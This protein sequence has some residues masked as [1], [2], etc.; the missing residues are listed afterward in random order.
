[1]RRHSSADGHRRGAALAAAAAA[2]AL[3]VLTPSAPARAD[4]PWCALGYAIPFGDVICNTAVSGAKA[5]AKV[6]SFAEDPL[7]YLQ[8][9]L[10]AGSDSALTSLLS[11][12][13]KG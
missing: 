4:T 13:T 7:G 6:T 11:E 12:T 5:A 1:M 9:H 2:V 3:S 10:T 8:Q